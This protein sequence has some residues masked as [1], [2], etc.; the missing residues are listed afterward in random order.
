M[1]KEAKSQCSYGMK[2]GQGTQEEYD[3]F[4][5]AAQE[6]D[7]ISKTGSDKFP[8]LNKHSVALEEGSTKSL[9]LN[10]VKNKPVWSSGS[11]QIAAVDKDGNV[12]AKKAGKT[13]IYAKIGNITYICNVKVVKKAA[14]K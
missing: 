1:V 10:R 2:H 7:R 5:Y 8:A 14:W 11:D 13:K 6:I 12:T 4:L 9:K 3:Q